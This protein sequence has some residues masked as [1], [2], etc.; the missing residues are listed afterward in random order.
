M[1][2]TWWVQ[3]GAPAA[4]D[5]PIGFLDGADRVNFNYLSTITRSGGLL[6]G[7]AAAFVWRPWRSEPPTCPTVA[8]LDI[9]P[10]SVSAP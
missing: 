6:L 2:L 5:G 9:A 4:I 8:P 7:A 3:R 10:A 1:A